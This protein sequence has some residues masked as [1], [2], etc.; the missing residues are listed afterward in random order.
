MET[1]F[2]FNLSGYL[3]FPRHVEIFG[4]VFIF[5]VD[6]VVVVAALSCPPRSLIASEWKTQPDSTPSSTKR[7]DEQGRSSN[8]SFKGLPGRLQE[9]IRE[10]YVLS[11]SSSFRPPLDQPASVWENWF[12]S[13]PSYSPLSHFSSFFFLF[14]FSGSIWGLFIHSRE[15]F[16]ETEREKRE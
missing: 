5:I 14:C 7:W 2:F 15:Q 9:V 13:L 6:V 3:P 1:G 11:S 10:K 16:C 4:L 12:F 8:T